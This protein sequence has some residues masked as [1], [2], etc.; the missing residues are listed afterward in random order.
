[1]S[2][3]F[4]HLNKSENKKDFDLGSHLINLMFKEPFYTRIFRSL[5]KIESSSVPTAGVTVVDGNFTLYW[6]RDFLSSL[7][8]IEV[9]GLLKHEA[10][11]LVFGHTT[12]R[13]RDPHIIWNYATDLAINCLIPQ[14]ELPK[15]GLIPGVNLPDL[16]EEEVERLTDKQIKTYEKFRALIR[17]L[18]QNKTSEYYFDI[19][20]KSEEMQD[21]IDEQMS[22][23]GIAI[24][25][26]DF[27]DVWDELSNEESDIVKAKLD[28]IIKDAAKEGEAKGWGSIPSQLRKD[29]IKRFSK[30]I[31]WA[32]VLRRFCGHIKS[33]ERIS[34]VKRLN[35]KYPG[36]HPG[37][38]KDYK[39]KLNIYVDESGSMSDDELTLLYSELES[40]SKHIDFY[41]YKFDTRVDLESKMFWKKGKRI[42]LKRNLNGGTSFC[43]PTNHAIKNKKNISGYII[44]TDGGAPKPPPSNGL[45]RAWIVTPKNR[46]MF[47]KDRL[48]TLINMN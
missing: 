35:R 43:A 6:N 25:G 32:S 28:E 27:H 8:P 23:K 2:N 15:G 7:A 33:N 38:K 18:P 48:D 10:L 44:M 31:D 3:S 19:L 14:H 30:Q 36:I 29:L 21:L 16:E 5:N 34:N 20:S 47:E 42:N 1:M 13:R 39:P 46:L 45:R 37:I 11:H 26:F 24:D 22:A 41:I 12:D 9:I 40:L 17:K 4:L